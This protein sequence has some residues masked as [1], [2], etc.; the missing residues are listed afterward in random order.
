MDKYI[1]RSLKIVSGEWDVDKQSFI[2]ALNE[3]KNR[4]YEL[5]NLFNECNLKGLSM[6]DIESD[7]NNEWNKLILTINGR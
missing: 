2:H 7:L 4:K 5:S 1:Q 3:L 6:Q